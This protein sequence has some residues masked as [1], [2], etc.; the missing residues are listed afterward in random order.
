[1]EPIDFAWL[2]RSGFFFFFPALPILNLNIEMLYTKAITTAVLFLWRN[3]RF[4]FQYN[5]ENKIP[6]KRRRFGFPHRFLMRLQL[7]NINYIA[8][9]HTLARSPISSIILP[10]AWA[11]P[12]MLFFRSCHSSAAIRCPCWWKKNKNME[13]YD[14]NRK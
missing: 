5:E 11:A 1:M 12:A 6:A 9:P 13:I 14:D 2:L 4:E 3:G 7:K 10:I 8:A